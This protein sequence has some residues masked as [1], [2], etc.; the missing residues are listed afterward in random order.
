MRGRAWCNSLNKTATTRAT[1]TTA[2]RIE[3]GTRAGTLGAAMYHGMKMQRRTSTLL[4]QGSWRRRA[5]DAYFVAAR[6]TASE[7]RDELAARVRRLIGR[8]VAAEDIYA[9]AGQRLAV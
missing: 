3:S 8:Q 5:A 4:A 7:L 6:E 2:Y 1:M 9:D